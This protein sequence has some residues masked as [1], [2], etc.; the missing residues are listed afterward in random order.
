MDP[1]WRYDSFHEY[2]IIDAVRKG[3]V[4]MVKLL[5]ERGAD[6]NTKN[7]HRWNAIEIAD[8]EGN[9]EIVRLLLKAGSVPQDKKL[10]IPGTSVTVSPESAISSQSK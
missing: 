7:N 10:E 2:P 5:L 4:E 3:N 1:N 8:R 9:E 6:P